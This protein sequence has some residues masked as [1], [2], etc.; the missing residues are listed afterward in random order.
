MGWYYY[1][2]EAPSSLPVGGGEVVAVR[3]FSKVF[4]E[5]RSEGAPE[6][7]RLLAM[8]RLCVTSWP[9]GQSPIESKVDLAL[10]PAMGSTVFAEAIREGSS[11]GAVVAVDVSA[12]DVGEVGSTPS[13]RRVSL[14]RK[15]AKLKAK[16]QDPALK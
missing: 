6:L 10:K 15:A 2:G 14:Q 9:K 11:Q 8:G 4:V 13:K 12:V 3:P 16:S 1:T 7:K 5:E